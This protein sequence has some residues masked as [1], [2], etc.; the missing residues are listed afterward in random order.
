MSKPKKSTAAK[1][2]SAPKKK[3]KVWGSTLVH[4]VKI[5]EADTAEDAIL[6][7]DA[8]VF[9]D[10]V[11]LAGGE[12]AETVRPVTEAGLVEV[13][14]DDEWVPCEVDDAIEVSR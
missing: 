10:D 6:A 9:V 14:C 3:W 2:E 5:V 4:V 7:L 13:T 12:L 8:A 11:T 1:A